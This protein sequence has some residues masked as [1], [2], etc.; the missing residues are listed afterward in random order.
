MKT[1][2]SLRVQLLQVSLVERIAIGELEAFR[3]HVERL[4]VDFS[5]HGYGQSAD[6]R[7]REATLVRRDNL[8]VGPIYNL[9]STYQYSDV[10]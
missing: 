5:H 2:M 4:V 3:C 9:L 10:V 6:L 1:H 8:P 7:D